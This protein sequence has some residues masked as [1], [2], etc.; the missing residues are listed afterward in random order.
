[1]SLDQFGMYRPTGIHPTSPPAQRAG[2]GSPEGVKLGWPGD[3]YFDQTGSDQYTKATGEGT[4][5]GW[6]RTVNL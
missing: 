5:T 4:T 3:I 6:L 1:M 2:S